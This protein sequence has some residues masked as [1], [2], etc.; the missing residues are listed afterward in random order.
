MI[1]LTSTFS[2]LSEFSCKFPPHT[3]VSWLVD[4][5][6]LQSSD[7]TKQLPSPMERNNTVLLTI[8]C[9]LSIAHSFTLVVVFHD[10]GE[11]MESFT[12]KVYEPPVMDTQSM[13][14][15]P[16]RFQSA[17][18]SGDWDHVASYSR[19]SSFI[20]VSTGKVCTVLAHHRGATDVFHRHRVCCQAP[21]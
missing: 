4:H 3:C 19:L 21:F 16:T 8:I 5:D 11:F 6:W 15:Y 18:H 7:V 20:F 10:S 13:C 12:N 9:C 17:R 1:Q 2:S 14:I